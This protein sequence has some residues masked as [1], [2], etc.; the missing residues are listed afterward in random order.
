MSR[1]LLFVQTGD[2]RPMCVGRVGPLGEIPWTRCPAGLKAESAEYGLS[3][4]QQ[5]EVES[6]DRWWLVE[7]ENADAGRAVIAMHLSSGSPVIQWT[8]RL[9]EGRILSSGGR[10]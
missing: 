3:L 2:A 9:P 10:K 1:V 6:A 5:H 7:C 4:A 8:G